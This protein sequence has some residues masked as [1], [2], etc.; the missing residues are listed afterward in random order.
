MILYFSQ[1]FV[2]GFPK[3]CQ[4]VQISG[5]Q[6]GYH[7]ID[8]EQDDLDPIYVFCNMSSSPVTAVLH[9][10]REDISYVSGYEAH[11]SYNGEVGFV[12]M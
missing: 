11:G 12:K 2:T 10:N 3:T 4:E 6:E 5:G 7:T 1:D 8:P 9:H